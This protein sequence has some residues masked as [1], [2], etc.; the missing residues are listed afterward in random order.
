ML[1]FLSFRLFAACADCNV[2]FIAIDALQAKRLSSLGYFRTTTPEIDKLA[3]GGVSF[4]QAISPSSWTIP[5]FLSV[6]SSTFPTEHTM[7]NRYRKFDKTEKII[8]N[9]AKDSPKLQVI[10]EVFKSEGYRTAAFTGGSGLSRE[11]GY[12]KG[13]DVFKDDISFGGLENSA[14]NALDWLS[15]LKKKE[16]FFLFLH[17]YDSHGQYSL[18]QDYN[19]K[20]MSKSKK[21]KGTKEE[22]VALREA[23]VEGKSTN[24]DYSDKEFWSAWYDSKI[25][26]ADRRIGQFLA[27]FGKL[28]ESKKTLIVFFSD[29]GTEIFEHD[30]IDHGHTL[31]DELIRVPLIFNGPGI[32]SNLVI[33]QQVGTI[34]VLPTVID[35]LGFKTPKDLKTQI[36]GRSLKHALLG[37]G[38]PSVDSF[39]ETD[40][41]DLIHKRSL[42]SKDHW[43]LIITLDDGS[44]ELYNLILDP[45][46][47]NNLASINKTK[48]KNMMAL[49]DKH[50][51]S[52][53]NPKN[54]FK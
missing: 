8:S 25:F 12:N 34:D 37:K 24:I 15:T 31:Y 29:H 32:K 48:V 54:K 50:L 10:A 49:L 42:R 41:R 43:K 7:T 51:A 1:S 47:K 53:A 2:V 30:A 13:F 20:F 27:D 33:K 22:E 38:I 40:Y 18:P 52:I 28:P 46:E 17:G 45:Q 21:Y 23:K 26:D 36:R 14:K 44:E 6:F 9:F 4:S 3:A 39:S 11:L 19:G 5:T 16:K 35:Y